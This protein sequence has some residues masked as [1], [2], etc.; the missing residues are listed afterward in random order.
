MK[1]CQ[2]VY[3]KQETLDSS[4]A[5][6]VAKVDEVCDTAQQLVDGGHYASTDITA[7]TTNLKQKYLN[8]SI[9]VI[10]S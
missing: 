9:D 6:L 1:D 4:L 8:Y 2:I 3:K 7:K 5:V 10:L